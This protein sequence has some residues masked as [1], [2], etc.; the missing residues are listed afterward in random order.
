MIPLDIEQIKK[1]VNGK[2]YHIP[3]E[4]IVIDSICTDSRKIVKQ[5]LFIALVGDN[6]DG[7]AFAELSIKDGA[8]AAIVDHK[9]DK[10]I[11]QIVVKDTRLALGEIANFVR[12][13]STAKIV[14]LTGSSGKTS[15]KEMTAAI[16]QNCGHTLYTQG[17]FNNDIGVPLTLLRLTK[18]DQF[19]VIELGANHIGEIAYTTNIVKPQSTLINNI[20]EAHIEGFGSLEGVAKAKG[21]I[22]QG[23]TNGGMAIINLD[24]YS[25]KWFT[26]LT[27]KTFWTFSLANSSADFYA[28]NIQYAQHTTFTLHTPKGECAIILPLVGQHNVSNAI[29]ASALALSV[30]ATFNQ[31]QQGLAILKPVR[32][33]LFPIKLNQTQ[34]IWDDTYNANVGSM[35]AAVKVLAKGQGY[36][37]LVVGDMGELGA[38]A[39]KYHR[40]IGELAHDEKIDCV[41]SVGKLSQ[42]ISQ[43]SGVGHHF[44]N[45]QDAVNYLLTLLCQH[46]TLT[47][48]IKGSRSAKMEELIK[49]IQIGQLKVSQ[50]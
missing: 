37:I 15:V 1:I 18:Q 32:G 6:F 22:F 9:L 39:E 20:A 11:P 34:L 44:N 36:R 29:A 25:D 26:Q 5:S 31:I 24:S 43:Y 35:S 12:Q 14:A 23:L 16:L 41:V 4:S 27:N 8:I 50:D 33:R 48:L 17:N 21:E 45:K 28:T 38:E 2:T 30:G 46:P 47:M 3:D 13:K 40:Q 19:A 10:A 42:F 7:H 49:K